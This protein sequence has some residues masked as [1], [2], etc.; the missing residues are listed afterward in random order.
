MRGI[1]RIAGIAVRFVGL[2]FNFLVVFYIG[3]SYSADIT[4]MYFTD[5]SLLMFVSVL[6][7]FGLEELIVKYSSSDLAVGSTLFLS[8]LIKK[9]PLFLAIT[10]GLGVLVS[11]ASLVSSNLFNTVS[12]IL[13]YNVSA[14]AFS[15]LN[16]S[17]QL[18]KGSVPLFIV[19]P[20]VF[21]T[22]LVFSTVSCS[23]DIIKFHSYSYILS[24]FGY[25]LI[26]RGY[27]FQKIKS[28]YRI[29]RD[30]SP[31]AFS[32]ITAGL[33]SYLSL[34]L[35]GRNLGS[36][37]FV[38]WNYVMKILQ[39]LTV[40]VMLSNIYFGPF[41]RQLFL[42]KKL[43]NLRTL[44]VRQIIVSGILLIPFAIFSPRLAVHFLI[45]S[46][47]QRVHFSSLFYTLIVGYGVSFVLSSIGTL[48]IMV[49]RQNINAIVGMIFSS[50]LVG[51]IALCRD[52]NMITYAIVFSVCI[53]LPKV[54]LFVLMKR[55]M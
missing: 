14:L 48:Y 44:F 30:L 45:L 41:Y 5:Y 33:A 23:E 27:N 25:I 19:S 36:E 29:A 1:T 26:L 38:V 20:L 8:F 12:F 39:I 18:L 15:Y 3:Q 51:F 32:S 9:I 43:I 50:I 34:Y 35:L 54:F 47:I 16:G 10:I 7:R 4:A 17:N 46:E 42:A 24:V 37:E 22:M 49:D 31:L 28:E 13:G 55:M 2:L 21:M 6:G 53:A 52:E 11:I 40:G